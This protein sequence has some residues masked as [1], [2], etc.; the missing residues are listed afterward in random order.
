MDNNIYYNNIVMKN[1]YKTYLEEIRKSLETIENKSMKS[2][3]EA[4]ALIAKA[5]M[6]E[7]NIWT[8]GTGHSHLI[9]QEAMYRAGGLALINCIF[10][11]GVSLS[12]TPV[13]ISTV[14]ERFEPLATEILKSS[15]YKEGDVLIIHSVSGING[16]PVEMARLGREKG[17]SVV[18]ITNMNHSE[19][20]KSRH[21]SGKKLKDFADV[22]IDDGGLK[23]DA[24][25]EIKNIKEKVGATSTVTGASIMNMI[26]IGVTKTLSNLDYDVPIYYSS[27][28]DGG[29][30][31]N[32]AVKRKHDQNIFYNK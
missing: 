18:A 5:I 15:N 23:G 19:Q 17:M 1:V 31:H 28:V 11:E 4:V 27:N 22:V 3:E 32:D 2:I 25:V 30:N 9:A 13:T 21:S 6:N 14:L 10:C 26:V 16:L 12:A 24:V 7:R 20:T 29:D 8:F